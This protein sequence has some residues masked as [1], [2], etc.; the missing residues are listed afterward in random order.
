[1]RKELE[2]LPDDGFSPAV[3]LAQIED[4]DRQSEQK[5]VSRYWRGLYFVLTRRTRDPDLAA[6]LAQDT[7]VIVIDKARNGGIENPSG[8][9]GFIR[10][11]GLNLL[12]AHYRKERRRST[13]SH[14]EFDIR[15]PD[16]SPTL[17]RQLQAKNAFNLVEQLMNELTVERD[18][19]I[20]KCYFIYEKDKRQICQDWDLSPEHF[21]RVLQ[22]ARTRLK[23][24]T[25]LKLDLDSTPTG[26][27]A[28]SLLDT[29]LLVLL[30]MTIFY[31]TA[32][33]ENSFDSQVRESP[34]GQHLSLYGAGRN[35]PA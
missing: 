7:F 18:R 10:Q 34:P 30:M 15:I 23:Q 12:T 8:L 19:Q 26:K 25:Y 2:S 6:D 35:E 1:M 14:A 9:S 11:V 3:L 29:T 4:G 27:T 17:Y 28:A 21:D 22:R 32:K 20:L 24:L 33:R 5:L 13:D 16:D 31:L